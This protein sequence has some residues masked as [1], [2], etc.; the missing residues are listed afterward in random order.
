MNVLF[1]RYWFEKL[2]Y[3]V[4]QCSASLVI[5]EVVFWKPDVNSYMYNF[6][7]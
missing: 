4:I 6:I 7:G 3:T 5:L 1:G 2:F